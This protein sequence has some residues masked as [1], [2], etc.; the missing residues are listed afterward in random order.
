MKKIAFCLLFAVAFAGSAFAQQSATVK[1]SCL[2]KGRVE[3]VTI[4][5]DVK[6]EVVNI[7]ADI[8]VEF[9]TAGSNWCGKVELVNAGADVKVEIVDAGAD[10]KIEIVDWRDSKELFLKEYE[11]VYGKPF[12]YRD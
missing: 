3:L 7:G 11:R 10:F 9:V 2:L 5:A 1:D 8:H 4:G 12:K 6:V